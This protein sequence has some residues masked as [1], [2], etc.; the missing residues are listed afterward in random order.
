LG[1]RRGRRGKDLPNLIKN[2]KTN[3][4]MKNISLANCKMKKAFNLV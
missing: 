4:K 2:E 1:G 3:S